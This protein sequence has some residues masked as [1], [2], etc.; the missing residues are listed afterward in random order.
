MK[1]NKDIIRCVLFCKLIITTLVAGAQ[2]DD[3]CISK[4]F[5][6]R[7]VSSSKTANGETDYKGPTSVFTTNQRIEYL[8]KY[9]NY[10]CKFFGDE[11]L[12]QQVISEK[13][14]TKAMKQLKPQPLPQVRK[15]IRLYD[16]W[17]FYCYREGQCEEYDK[18]LKLWKN[19]NNKI[20]I[21][22]GNLV[23]KDAASLVLDITPQNWRFKLQLDMNNNPVV[24]KFV[25]SKNRKT[26]CEFGVDSMH[27]S[28]YISN[29]KRYYSQTLKT[30]SLKTWLAE[31]DLAPSEHRFNLKI[32]D[33][34]VS[35]FELLSDI[36]LKRV[37]QL[38]IE[39][40]KGTVIDN[41]WG[42]GYKKTTD[43]SMI[44]WPYYV[45]TFI[46]DDFEVKQNIDNWMRKEYDDSLWKDCILPKAHGS[47]RH[48][49]E[50]IYLRKTVH[51][52]NFVRAF[53]ELEAMFPNGELWING[54]IVEV[55]KTPHPQMIDI[56]Q[57]LSPDAENLIALK[58]NSF[59]A[60]QSNAMHHAP[61][62][63]NIGWFAGRSSLHLTQSTMITDMFVY[64]NGLS[65]KKAMIT[66]EVTIENKH[67]TFY[68]G[69]LNVLL[70]EWFPVEAGIETNIDSI[71]IS[72]T[73]QEIKTF[74]LQFLVDNVK[75]WSVS[76]PQLYQVRVLLSNYNSGYKREEYRAIDGDKAKSR[77]LYISRYTDDYVLTTGFRTV[78]QEGGIFR[79]N[80]KPE[81]LKAPLYFGQRFPLDKLSTDLLAPS[82]E[83]LMKELLAVK[84]MNGNGMRMSVHWS[85]NYG[86]DGTN[87][88]RMLEMADQLGLMY[89]WTT[90]S[91]IRVRSPFTMDFEGLGKYVRQARNSPSVIIWQPSNHPDLSKWNDAMVF[92]NKVYNI[93]HPLDTTRLITPSADL[94]HIGP[95]ND[96][97]TINNNGEKDDNCD[98][99]WTA[100]RIARGSMDYPT[101]FGQDWEYLRLWPFPKKWKG[102]VPI[103]DYLQS[104]KRAYFNFEQE[105]SIGQM[106]WKL[107]KGSPIYKYHSYEW[108]YDIGSIG[109]LLTFDE[110]KES[111]AWQAFSA[112]EC[113]RK[114]RWLDYDGLSWCCMWGGP[115][116]GTYQK[117]LIDALGNKK[118]S[119][120][121]NQMGFQSVLAGSKDV[122]IVY[123]PSDAPEL[124]VLNI[125]SERTVDVIVEII[126][127]EGELMDKRIYQNVALPSGRTSTVLGKLELPKLSDGYY[128]FGYQI[129]QK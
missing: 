54:K 107:Y 26:V 62:D 93:I 92:Y 110:W 104:K 116:M 3:K 41:I 122:D 15:E 71:D 48:E 49:G 6:L 37:D 35:D 20:S 23:F 100:P 97:G 32:A 83:D 99:V 34:L 115:N 85:D 102:N 112:Y 77:E 95:H 117:P 29:G 118:L 4:S 14:I 46:D 28:Y 52:G 5:E 96:D 89:I 47:E 108:D 39:G 21:D 119:F 126:N 57:Y 7:Y 40:M 11:K 55:I 58:V 82:S 43:H 13:E 78:G 125:G 121:T 127:E 94:R 120:Y 79:I 10:A 101:G 8:N 50:D 44:N 19:L 90:A 91:W 65:D 86:Q 74:K 18:R 59:K 103:N 75:L 87:D 61:T 64:T 67:H 129:M 22:D 70:K 16:G 30:L 17:K 12:D 88:P 72:L 114:M 84:K 111:Q 1:I 56:T 63:L 60:D 36:S 45:E 38:I 9:A 42:V 124:L 25:D 69:K 24:I 68:E 73:P 76:S 53:Y 105:E 106:N 33:K 31:I 66:A 81:L 27:R 113:I 109:R 80:G 51:V 98:P 2:S 123:G 128:F